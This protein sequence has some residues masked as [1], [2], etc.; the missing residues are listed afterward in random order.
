MHIQNTP[1]LRRPSYRH[2]CAVHRTSPP[3]PDC[4]WNFCCFACSLFIT[5]TTIDNHDAPILI[6]RVPAPFRE[7]RVPSMV[8]CLVL[9]INGPATGHASHL[10][11]Q[12]CMDATGAH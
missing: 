7:H 5:T 2:Y 10:V 12:S 1:P 3:A 11:G 9:I 8:K 6:V 4:R